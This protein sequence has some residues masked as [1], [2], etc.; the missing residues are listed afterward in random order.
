MGYDDSWSWDPDSFLDTARDLLGDAPQ[1][2][3][4]MWSWCGEMSDED[5]SVERYLEMMAQLQ[6]EYTHVRFVHMTGHTDGD[7][8]ALSRNNDRIRQHVRERGGI[9]YDFADIES[10][11]PGGTCYPNTDDSCPWCETWCDQH[12]EDCVSLPA[13]DDE[14]AHSHGFNCRLKGQALWWLSARLAGWDG[15]PP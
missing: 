7:N 14:C 1:A 8:D 11:D 15:T 13:S 6:A 4:F 12:P 5:T 9:L 10:C 3:A 2:T